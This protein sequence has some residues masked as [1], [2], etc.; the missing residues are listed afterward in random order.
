M[1]EK[2]KKTN[3]S[4]LREK[5]RNAV[6]SFFSS[7]GESREF[8]FG[9][10]QITFDRDSKLFESTINI[11]KKIYGKWELLDYVDME[12]YWNCNPWIMISEPWVCDLIKDITDLVVIHYEDE[13]IKGW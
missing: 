8:V 1:T 3:Y 10:I 9:N 6:V 12:G 4:Q 11:K 13:K 5:V 2:N 7:C